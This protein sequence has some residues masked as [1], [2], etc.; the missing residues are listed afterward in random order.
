M[1]FLGFGQTR[2]RWRN[3]WVGRQRARFSR[4]KNGQSRF[5]GCKRQENQKKKKDGQ[6]LDGEVVSAE[7]RREL[8][9]LESLSFQR[10]ESRQ[11][12]KAGA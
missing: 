6:A 4:H 12:E 10:R 11:K 7:L 2:S 5:F 9:G 8:R 3:R 1:R